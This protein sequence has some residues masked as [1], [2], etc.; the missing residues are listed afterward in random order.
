MTARSS[1]CSVSAKFCPMLVEMPYSG[2]VFNPKNLPKPWIRFRFFF[3]NSLAYKEVNLL[4]FEN[5]SCKMSKNWNFSTKKM[6]WDS[7]VPLNLKSV[8]RSFFHKGLQSTDVPTD[9]P[10]D[11]QT[12]RPRTR[13]LGL[14]RAAKKNSYMSIIHYPSLVIMCP[15]IKTNDFFFGKWLLFKDNFAGPKR[16]RPTPMFFIFICLFVF[17]FVHTFG[18]SSP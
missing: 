5:I 17:L 6:V 8:L 15:C 7:T 3:L 10:I 1:N 13:L 16:G 9:G 18:C 2:G 14:L 11:R 4:V 12:D